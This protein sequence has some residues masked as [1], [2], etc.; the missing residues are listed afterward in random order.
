MR[1][2]KSYRNS[3]FTLIE[4]IVGI[5]VLAISL[6]VI[7]SF[8]A[9]QAVRSIDPIYQVR[10]AE[11]G[12]S[13]MNEIL[14]KSFDENS[15]HTGGGLWRCGETGQP[16]CTAADSYGP[17][18]ETRSQY[19]DVDDYHTNG[20]F[21]AIDDSLGTNLANIYRNYSYRVA[22]DSSENGINAAKRIDLWIRAPNGADYA[23]SAYRWNY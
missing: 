21:I 14:S 6:V 3:G 2:C 5:V 12:S 16:A 9:P 20:N 4:L 17:D 22:I 8:L 11:L 19:N 7:T 10:S 13:L 23:F 1:P 15:D 18:G